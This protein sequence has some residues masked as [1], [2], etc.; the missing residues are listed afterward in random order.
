MARRGAEERRERGLNSQFANREDEVPLTF[1]QMCYLSCSHRKSLSQ[2]FPQS[3]VG[4]LYH[5]QVLTKG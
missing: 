1:R 2:G 5:P 4:F 3:K